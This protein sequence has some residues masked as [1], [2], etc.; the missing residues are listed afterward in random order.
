MDVDRPSVRAY[1]R[2]GKAL[3]A[4]KLQRIPRGAAR[5][6]LAV[7]EAGNHLGRLQPAAKCRACGQ[8][9]GPIDY[10]AEDYSKPFGAH[11]TELP[12][13]YLCHMLI[14]ARFRHPAQ[15]DS[16]REKIAAGM[17]FTPLSSRGYGLFLAFLTTLQTGANHQVVNPP[18]DLVLDK[19]DADHYL[20]ASLA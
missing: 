2:L 9:H 3:N 15:W 10:H 7:G 17:Q 14:H 16:Y 19:I 13:C 8:E 1:G 5:E 18:A 4:E 11:L 20:R 6:I 12:L